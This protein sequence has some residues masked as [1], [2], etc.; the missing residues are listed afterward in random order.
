MKDALDRFSFIHSSILP[1]I[2]FSN[3]IWTLDDCVRNSPVIFIC[4]VVSGEGGLFEYYEWMMHRNHL[5]LPTWLCQKINRAINF[6]KWNGSNVQIK[7]EIFLNVELYMEEWHIRGMHRPIK[8]CCHIS[9]W[10]RSDVT[11]TFWPGAKMIGL[12]YTHKYLRSIFDRQ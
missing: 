7:T 10:N 9:H 2:Q 8:Y 12:H 4:V 11:L 3:R 6:M 5:N 1:Y